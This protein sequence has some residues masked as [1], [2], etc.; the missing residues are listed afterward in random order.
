MESYQA[1]GFKIGV[2]KITVVYS[3]LD[4]EAQPLEKILGE[5]LTKT[6][7]GRD[8]DKRKDDEFFHD[9]FNWVCDTVVS[10]IFSKP[11][12]AYRG[13]VERFAYG[14][15]VK[16][17]RNGQNWGVNGKSRFEKS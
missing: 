15:E 6:I 4:P 3:G 17:N 1:V 7:G 9:E 10:V 2:C 8:Q 14:P 13:K 5:T 12:T 16:T 11:L